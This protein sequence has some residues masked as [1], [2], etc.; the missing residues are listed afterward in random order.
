MGRLFLSILFILVTVLGSASAANASHSESGLVV[1]KSDVRPPDETGIRVHQDSPGNTFSDS[2]RIVTAWLLAVSLF[3]AV[4]LTVSV[5]ISFY[6]YRWRR[7]L[8]SSPHLLVPEELGER[9][10]AYE[11]AIKKVENTLAVGTGRLAERSEQ[12]T[13]QISNLIETFMTL[14]GAIDEKDQE[15]KRLKAGYDAQIFRRFLFRFVRVHQTVKEFGENDEIGERDMS[16]VQRLLEDALDECGVEHFEPEIGTDYR[17]SQGVSDNPK[18]VSTD[19]PENSFKISEIVEP[20]Y[21]IRG[22]AGTLD[23]IL[24]AKVTIFVYEAKGEGNDII[25]RN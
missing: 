14:Q 7:I 11:T 25:H 2:S 9:I 18:S 24:P 15:I 20:G 23:V 4:A 22:E 13:G 17:E 1:T 12:M 3:L 19:V 21:R 10:K 16:F 6:L 5:A 8:L